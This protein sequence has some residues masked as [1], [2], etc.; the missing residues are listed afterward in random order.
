MKVCYLILETDKPVTESSHYLRG[1]FGNKYRDIP[2]MHHHLDD[3]GYIY[4]YPRIQYKILEGVPFVVGIAEGAKIIDS[5]G[6]EITKLNLNGSSYNVGCITKKIYD[7]DPKPTRHN[8]EY[9]FVTEWL[10]LNQEN[11]REYNSIRDHQQRK[12]FINNIL[13]GN[14][15]SF[16]KGFGIVCDRTIHAHTHIDPTKVLFKGINLIGFNGRFRV[17]FDFP[18]FIGVGKAASFGFGSVK[19]VID[20]DHSQ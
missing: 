11:R 3:T 6:D 5:I 18:D 20:G 4:L 19:K 1:F 16:C 7:C 8:I 15:L 12:E 9:K 2:I 10:P 14:V 17:N 13:V